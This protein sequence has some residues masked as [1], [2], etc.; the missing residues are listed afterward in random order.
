VNFKID[1]FLYIGVD[2]GND[3]VYNLLK[4]KKC[5]SYF[6]RDAKKYICSLGKKPSFAKHYVEDIEEVKFIFNKLRASTQKRKK[7][8]SQ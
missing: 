3:A 6:S 8:R 5:D 1:F 7:T 4:S 2:T